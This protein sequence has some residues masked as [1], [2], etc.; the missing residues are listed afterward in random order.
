MVAELAEELFGLAAVA[1]AAGQCSGDGHGM[2]G[3]AIAVGR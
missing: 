2:G 3:F 1:V